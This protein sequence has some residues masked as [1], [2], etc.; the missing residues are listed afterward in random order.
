MM[1]RAPMHTPRAAYLRC[2]KVDCANGASFSGV[3]LVSPWISPASGQVEC[4]TGP[5]PAKESR[6]FS[7]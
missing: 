1:R 4:W 6:V 5:G 7:T 3:V 2:R